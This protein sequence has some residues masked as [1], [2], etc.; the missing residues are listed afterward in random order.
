MKRKTIYLLVALAH[1][2]L[3]FIVLYQKN[4]MVSIGY[5][6]QQLDAACQLQLEEKLRLEHQLQ[7][8][9][10]PDRIYAIATKELG[11]VPLKLKQIK[12]APFDEEQR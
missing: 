12:Q 7:V 3:I 2:A 6:K 5:T 11:M 1:V 10:S 9:K 8:L 4:L